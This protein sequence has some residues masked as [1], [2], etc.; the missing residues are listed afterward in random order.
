[1]GILVFKELYSWKFYP[2]CKF[3]SCSFYLQL[4]SSFYS[5]SGKSGTGPGGGGFRWSIVSER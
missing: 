2:P 3:C 5:S 1:M 4:F